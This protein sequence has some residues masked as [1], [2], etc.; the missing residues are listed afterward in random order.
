MS[1]CLSPAALKTSMIV[2]RNNLPERLAAGWL[3]LFDLFRE[4]V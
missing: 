3:V 1:G 4:F 2:F